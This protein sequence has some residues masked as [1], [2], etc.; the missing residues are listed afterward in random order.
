MPVSE[1]SVRMHGFTRYA[2]L[3][4]ALKI[5]LSKARLLESEAVPF[6]RALGRVLAEDVVSELDVPPFD[7]S[8][9]DGYAVRAADTFEASDLKPANLRIMGSVDIGV[10]SKLHVGKGVAI[11]I[12]TGTS[13]PKGSDAVVMVEHT[14]ARGKNIAVSAP[15]TPGKNVSEKG[16][17]VKTGEVVLGRGCQLRPQDVGTLASIGKTRVRVSRRPEV[18]ILATGSELRKPGERLGRA[19]ITDINS[20]SL[21]AAAER[22]GGLSHRLGI[23]PDKP[24]ELKRALRKAINYDMVLASG[25]SSVGEHDIVP[26][27]IA[28]LGQLMFHGV[29]IRPGG[30]TAFGII[31]SKPI[32]ALPGFPV[33]SLIAFDML[34]GPA[35]RQM[36]GLPVGRGYP[37]VRARLARKVSSTLGRADIVRVNIRSK[38]G[39]L[40][41]DPIRVTGSSVLSSMTKADGFVIVPEDVEGLDES[42]IVE[43][44]LYS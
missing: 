26:D 5:V 30:P 6:D 27:I 10:V 4:D 23:V 16:E 25:G 35:L 14:R 31:K 36:Q 42:K 22:F 13:L 24:E 2:R 44:E 8:A 32:F 40:L 41:A 15:V 34:V 12:M 21:A 20:Y 18:A 11:K 19:E 28:E 9:V 33:S 38:E 29:A 3:A 7:R 43:V 37:K 39:E 1:M 17:D